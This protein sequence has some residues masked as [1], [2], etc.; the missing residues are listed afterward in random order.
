MVSVWFIK[1]S[2]AIGKL[3]CSLRLLLRNA[4]CQTVTISIEVV[5]LFQTLL[6]SLGF[7]LALSKYFVVDFLFSL[8]RFTP[9]MTLNDFWS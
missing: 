7:V 1:W 4:F 8:L 3:L 9:W 5:V 6:K 2:S